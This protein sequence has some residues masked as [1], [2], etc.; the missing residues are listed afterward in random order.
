MIEAKDRD[1]LVPSAVLTTGLA[2]IAFI[3]WP[4]LQFNGLPDPLFALSGWFKWTLIAAGVVLLLRVVR[5]MRADVPNPLKHML[6]DAEAHRMHLAVV[7]LAMLLGALDLYAF[8]IVKPELNVLFPF[9]ADQSLADLDKAIFGVDP[10]R[11]FRGW[12]KPFVGY[13]YSMGWYLSLL[14][15]FFWVAIKPPSAKKSAGLLSYF[16]IWSIFG[17]VAQALL[18]SAGPIFFAR[19]GLGDRFAEMPTIEISRFLSDY[20]WVTFQTRSLAQGAGIS[21]MP[22][23]HIATV[24]WL[25]I[26]LASYRSRWT[27]PGAILAL[28][29]YG[30]SIALG[31]HY[32]TDGI[33]GALGAVACFMLATAIVKR[34]ARSRHTATNAAP[35]FASN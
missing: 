11:L 28:L 17:P 7:S 27:L 2:A 4:I 25:V 15:T 20:L 14:L 22:S 26:C 29:I 18:S 9:W 8:M 5:M 12:D 31:W 10:W 34:S 32:A 35:A 21:A 33:V 6:R 30:C 13:F 19:V 16:I 24:S 1:W 23:M 3:L